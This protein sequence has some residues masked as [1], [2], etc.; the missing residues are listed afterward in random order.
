MSTVEL[1]Y[2]KLDEQKIIKSTF[3]TGDTIND[4]IITSGIL[5]KYPEIDLTINKVG[6]YNQVKKLDEPVRANDR[7]EIYRPLIANPK[8][9]RRKRAIQQKQQGLI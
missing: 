1:I 6:I 4:V 2:A 9:V 7:I 8:D 3:K 5:E